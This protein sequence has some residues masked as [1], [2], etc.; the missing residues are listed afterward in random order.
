MFPFFFDSTFLILIPAM[1]LAF[2]AQNRVRSVFERYAQERNMAGLTGAEAAQSLLH[3]YGLDHIQVEMTESPMGD[4][5]DPREGVVRLSPQVYSTASVT[6]L[7]VA[8]HEVGHAVQHSRGYLPL[9]L[10]N[11]LIPVAQIGSSLAFPL[12]FLGLI[13]TIP[14]LIKIGVFAFIGVVAFQLITLPV[15]YNASHRALAMLEEN[16]LVT[17]FEF[18]SLDAVLNA[19]ALTYVAAAFMAVSNLV[20]LLALAGIFRDET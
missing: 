16:N 9:N 12:L 3:I 1:I 11:S 6:S 10:R 4:H 19:A 20:R 17:P 18:R 15:E 13:M 14:S 2:Y 7:G 8:A 5:Y